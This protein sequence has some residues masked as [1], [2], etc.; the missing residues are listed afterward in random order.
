MAVLELGNLLLLFLLSFVSAIIDL[1]LGMGYGFTVTPAMLLLG[2]SP[3]EAVPPVL[4]TSFI[5]GLFSSFFNHRFKNV[6]FSVGGRELKIALFTGGLGILGA[7]VGAIMSL[8]LPQRITGI[9]IGV[10]VIASGLLVIYSKSLVSS[11][12]W[13]RMF[14]ISAIGSINKG[15]TGS[16]FGPVITTGAILS[17]LSEKASISIQAFAEALVSIVGF[18]AYIIMR[19]GL[20]YSVIFSMSLG[21]ILASPFAAI[22]MSRLK[23]NTMRILVGI[24]ALLIGAGTLLKYL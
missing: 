5:G 10:L 13:P 11:F 4:F 23:G 3:S 21:V 17:G 2:Y 12:S 7:I 19:S 22:I 9:Y 15:L 16:G 8:N 20:N 18:S 24:L 14:V 1:S 6:D